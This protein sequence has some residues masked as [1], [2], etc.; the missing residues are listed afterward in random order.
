MSSSEEGEVCQ[1]ERDRNVVANNVQFMVKNS[2][3]GNDILVYNG[4]EYSYTGENSKLNPSDSFNDNL[5]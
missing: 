3:Q 4:Y 2:T 1:E 5:C